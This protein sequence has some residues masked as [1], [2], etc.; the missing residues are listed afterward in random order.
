V[1]SVNLYEQEVKRLR[2]KVRSEGETEAKESKKAADADKRAAE[3]QK[4]ANRAS[5]PKSKVDQAQRKR[6]EANKA[7]TKAAKATAAK[8]KAEGDMHGAQRK[9]D[10]ARVKEAKKQRDRDERDRARVERARADQER[11][12][13]GE[14]RRREASRDQE[15]ARLR[16]QTSE[17]QARLHEHLSSEAP[18]AITVLFVA[19]SPEDQT[20]LRLDRE[21]R[22]VQRRL[23]ESD[24][25]DS[26]EFQWR[27]A[28]QL[29]DLIQIL[30]EVR[31]HVVHFSGHG[32]QGGLAFEND[33][34][35]TATL[36]N[37]QLAAFLHATV[38]RITL[39]VFN[40]CDSAAQAELAC[41]HLEASIGMDE[42]INDEAAQIFAG[43]LYNAI[44][45]GKSLAQAL[46]QAL[47]HTRL[48]LGDGSASGEPQL[49]AAS[50]IDA[51]EIYLVKPSA[52]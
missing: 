3:Y 18:E 27:P 7:R 47:V 23:R 51:A 12:A 32:S 42:P 16:S 43:Q 34:G 29:P 15:I 37:D 48:V 10:E 19:A 20:P 9:L 49:H 45:F 50:G 11:R 1:S 36:S 26:V 44:G 35:R 21:V 24:Y 39:V 46:E 41:L 22:E 31:P 25:R 38:D 4:E 30:N 14:Q 5:S 8:A 33:E 6:D 17:T 28:T 2:N 40:S 52:D 13:Q